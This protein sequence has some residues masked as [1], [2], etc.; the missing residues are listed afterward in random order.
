MHILIPS[1]TAEAAAA[2]YAIL[3]SKLTLHKLFPQSLSDNFE[4][5]TGTKMSGKSGG[6]ILQSTSGFALAA[7]GKSMAHQDD[8]YINSKK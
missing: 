3:N 8:E 4:L 2:I 1:D 5:A 6:L 7:R